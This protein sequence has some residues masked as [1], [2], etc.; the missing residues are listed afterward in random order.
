MALSPARAGLVTEQTTNASLWN[1]VMSSPA[2]TGLF[3]WTGVDYLG[4]ANGK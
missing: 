2:L 3:V 4:E 1:P